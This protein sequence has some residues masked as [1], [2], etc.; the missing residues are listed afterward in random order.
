M[1]DGNGPV[2]AAPVAQKANEAEMARARR[3]KKAFYTMGHIVIAFLICWIPFYVFF[4]VRFFTAFY[5]VLLFIHP[6]GA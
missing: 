6:F 3:E 4:L 5:F 1:T 2:K